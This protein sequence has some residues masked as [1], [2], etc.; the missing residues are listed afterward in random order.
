MATR[1]MTPCEHGCLGQCPKC[2]TLKMPPGVRGTSMDPKES[3]DIGPEERGP[4]P[5]ED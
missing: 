2:G 1:A 3:D 5:D 4:D